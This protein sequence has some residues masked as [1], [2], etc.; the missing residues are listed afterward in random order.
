MILWLNGPFGV[1]KSTV[2]AELV[3]RWPGAR[4]VDPERIGYVVQRTFWRG[5]DYQDVDLWRRLTVRAVARAH[6]RGPVIVPM[7]VLDPDVYTQITVGATVV[8]LVASRSTLIE[9]I[10]ASGEAVTWRRNQLDRGLAALAG[11]RMGTV[12]GT[13]GL[14]ASRIAEEVL[15]IVE[16]TERGDV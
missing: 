4:V 2:A 5:Q 3:D 1:G 15:S 16:A 12:I 7:A 6:R 8:T 13:D 11:G 14:S 10:V 9:R